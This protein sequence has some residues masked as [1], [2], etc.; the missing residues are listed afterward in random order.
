MCFRL[1]VKLDV[2]QT[3][4]QLARAEAKT[5]VKSRK[6]RAFHRAIRRDSQPHLVRK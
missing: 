3:V 1:S 2:E 6:F 5:P 4:V